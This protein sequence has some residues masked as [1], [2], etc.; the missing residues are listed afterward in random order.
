MFTVGLLLTIVI[1]NI[2]LRGLWSFVTLILIVVLAL[3]ISLF[4][5]GWDAIFDALAGLHIYINMAGYLFIGVV[6][7]RPVGA[8]RCSSSTGGRT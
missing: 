1:T 8:G 3:F 6:R 7:V 4:P 2:P 5:S